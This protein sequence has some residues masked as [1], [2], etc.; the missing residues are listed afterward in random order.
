MNNTKDI[1]SNNFINPD[2][3]DSNSINKFIIDARVLS[4][5][6]GL[7]LSE[8][9]NRLKSGE[10]NSLLDNINSRQLTNIKEQ[11]LKL[12]VEFAKELSH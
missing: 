9:E 3:E 12:L 11:K 7:P 5:V 4:D 8:V 10:L 1:I 2:K 6:I